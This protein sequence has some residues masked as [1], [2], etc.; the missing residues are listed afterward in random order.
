MNEKM[1]VTKNRLYLEDRK[2]RKASR[3]RKNMK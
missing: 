2:R 1:R 3:I